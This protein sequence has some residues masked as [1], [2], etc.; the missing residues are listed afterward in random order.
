V[1]R[2]L[3]L[4]VVPVTVSNNLSDDL[5]NWINNSIPAKHT[6]PF[7]YPILM[8]SSTDQFF[9]CKKT[10]FVGAMGWRGLI[11]FVEKTFGPPS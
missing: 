3:S 6:M 11:K 9:A 10:P 7:N 4:Y 5:K 2:Q 8:S 1:R